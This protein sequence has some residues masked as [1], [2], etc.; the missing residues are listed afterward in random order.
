MFLYFGTWLYSM[1]YWF[2]LLQC[3][4][5][6]VHLYM[7][8]LYSYSLQI[9]WWVD[10]RL[11]GWVIDARHNL[12]ANKIMMFAGI[13]LQAFLLR[14][15]LLPLCLLLKLLSI[16]LKLIP[17]T[18]HFIKLILTL[19]QIQLDWLFLGSSCRYCFSDHPVNW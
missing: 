15:F 3:Y 19:D 11:K 17:E 16:I 7:A 12:C 13:I 9:D 6:Q 5:Q 14:R 2:S 10:L 8:L 18:Q 1:L 4:L